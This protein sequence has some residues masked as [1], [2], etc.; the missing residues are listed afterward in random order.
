MRVPLGDLDE[1]LLAGHA[2]TGEQL[3][4]L[5]HQPAPQKLWADTLMLILPG[6]S[7]AARHAAIC[8]TAQQPV[9]HRPDQ[10]GTLGQRDELAR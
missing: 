4:D 5:A 8:S 10:A 6:S 2:A 3:V 1:E 9:G 7:P